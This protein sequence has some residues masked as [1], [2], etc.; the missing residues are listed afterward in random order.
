MSAWPA[1]TTALSW[2][3]VSGVGSGR[4]G[5]AAPGSSLIAR[6]SQPSSPPT[7]NKFRTSTV[8]TIYCNLEATGLDAGSV[9]GTHQQFDMPLN[10]ILVLDRGPDLVPLR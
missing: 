8:T 1:F 9:K 3:I 2:A 5:K 10:R 6:T 4:W 7:R